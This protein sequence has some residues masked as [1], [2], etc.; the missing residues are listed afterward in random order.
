MKTLFATANYFKD[1]I[2]KKR[3]N[4]AVAGEKMKPKE[5]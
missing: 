4:A 2:L 1:L 3:R 5:D